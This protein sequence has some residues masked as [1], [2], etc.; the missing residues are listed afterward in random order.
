MFLVMLIISALNESA[1]VN[2]KLIFVSVDLIRQVIINSSLSTSVALAIWLQL[3]NGRFDFSSGATMLLTAIIA[4][5]ITHQLGDNPVMLFSLSIIIGTALSLFT[6]TVYILGRLPVI[7]STIGMTLFY[8]SLTYLVFDGTG[9]DSIYTNAK[10]SVFGGLPFILIPAALAVIVFIIFNNFSL[11]GMQGKL[12]A[13][14]QAA[15]VHIG[16]NEK[17]NILISYIFSGIIIS[18]ASIIYVSQNQI[19]PKSGLA[20]SGVLFSYIVPV[21]IGIFIGKAS[22]DA[23]GIIS[24]SIGMQILN[25]GLNC[26]NMGGGGWNQIIIGVFM[27]SFYTFSSKIY[28]LRKFYSSFS[29][30]KNTIRQHNL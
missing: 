26:I 28:L 6:A 7:I 10:A 19:A 20:T 13:N 18:L 24:A 22:N 3:K 8:E 25:Y 5:N 17:R 4:G 12:L 16:I 2:G 30:K 27:L 29:N 21:F 9:V 11:A 15:S 14:N 1:Y 23:I